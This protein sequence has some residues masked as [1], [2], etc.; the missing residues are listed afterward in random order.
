[1]SGIHATAVV[2]DKPGGPPRIVAEADW[3][4]TAPNSQDYS[5]WVVIQMAPLDAPS[6]RVL[7]ILD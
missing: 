2:Q 6:I 5:E 4:P 7:H 1:V 3:S